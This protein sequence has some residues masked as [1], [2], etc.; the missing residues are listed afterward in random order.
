LAEKRAPVPLVGANTAPASLIT[1]KFPNDPYSVKGKIFGEAVSKDG[2][3]VINGNPDVPRNVDFVITKD[4]RLLL[5]TKHITLASKMD[6]R[7]AGQMKLSGRG[8]I[9]QID[10]RSGHYRPTIDDGLRVPEMLNNMGFNTAKARLQLYDFVVG[11]DGL[12]TR[13]VLIIN[14]DLK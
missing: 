6:V 10:N 1:N 4:G 9:R 7:A 13:K 12:V 8:E 11:A 2:R 5:G 3:I 14:R